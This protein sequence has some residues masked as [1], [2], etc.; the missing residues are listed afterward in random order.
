MFTLK[1][2]LIL[3]GTKIQQHGFCYFHPPC[4]HQYSVYEWMKWMTISCLRRWPYWGLHFLMVKSSSVLTTTKRQCLVFD[5][6]YFLAVNEKWPITPS[7]YELCVL[8][9]DQIYISG[10]IFNFYFFFLLTPTPPSRAYLIKNGKMS[11]LL[12]DFFLLLLH[13][14]CALHWLE[15]RRSSLIYNLRL[16]QI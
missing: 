14:Y 12:R 8:C 5:R 1:Q 4:R 7:P 15:K 2:I 16:A 9:H 10:P 3:R 11:F 13:G 6:S